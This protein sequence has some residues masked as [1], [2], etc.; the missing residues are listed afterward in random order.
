MTATLN[1]A[2]PGVQPFTIYTPT[3]LFFGADQ[4]GAFAQAV[5]GLGSR[6]F[7]MTGGGTVERLGYLQQLSDALTAAGVSTMHFAG[8]EANPDSATI[9]RAAAEA[10]QGGADLV[11]ALGGGSVMDAAK[12]VAALAV[13][14]EPDI[15]PFVIGEPRALALGEALPI[16]AVPTTAA[17]ASEVTHYAV[18]SN[19]DE[20]GK[21]LLTGEFL[22]PLAAWLNP[23]FT[24]GL[25]PTTTSD[26]AADILSHVFESYLLGGSDSVLADRYSEGVM[27]TVL[28]MLPR[29]LNDPADLA[30]R[31]TLMWA[32]TLALN[33]YQA[34]G[35]RPAQ[36]VLHSIEHALSAWCPELA[37]GRGLATLYPAYFRWLLANG[38]A[39]D[40]FAQLGARLFG[41]GSSEA[42]QAE[43][44]VERFERWLSENGLYQSLTDLGFAADDYPAIADYAVR[45]SGD[46]KQLDA[47]GALPAAEI[48]A[49]LK[50]TARQGRGDP[51][52]A[53]RARP[54]RG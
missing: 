31:G 47:L 49:I 3:R 35:R 17:T 19:R 8:V 52:H 4:L 11:L 18:V 27:E 14:D 20:R 54:R 45:T 40:R 30:A 48:V 39:Q 13:T 53:A 23:V 21:S 16:A 42:K 1:A 15:W 36:F 38:R 34:A 12:A 50:D 41:L 2:T 46:G 43:G 22:K 5:S 51:S 32:A 28:R 9:N 24:L 37:H 25:S 6:A 7:V 33:D 29:V 26:G 10:R 44:F